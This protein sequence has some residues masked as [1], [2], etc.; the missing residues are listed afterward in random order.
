MSIIAKDRYTFRIKL[1]SSL[2]NITQFVLDNPDINQDGLREEGY[3]WTD[4][5]TIYYMSK[6]ADNFTM[7]RGGSS[8]VDPIPSQTVVQQAEVVQ[9]GVQTGHE[10]DGPSI[11]WPDVPIVGSVEDY[12][13][14]RKPSWYSRM[15]AMVQAGKH[16][17][18]AGPPGIGKSSAVE[19][20]AAE[21]GKV[22]VNVS[23]DSG[24]RRRDLTGQAANVNSHTAFFAAEYIA[25]AV[26]GWWVKVDEANAAEPDALMFLNSQIA[27]PHTVNFYGKSMPVHPGFRLFITYNP[28]LVGTKPLPDS[29]KDRFFPIKLEFPTANAL[30]RML[31]ANGMPNTDW[32]KAIVG[33]GVKAWEYHKLGRMRYQITPRRLMDAVTLVTLAGDDV[34]DALDAAVISAVDNVAEVRVLSDLLKSIKDEYAW[35]RL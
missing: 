20:L 35:G 11:H 24:L 12:P 33:F 27:P 18:L 2:A 8:Y 4:I 30:R 21:Q 31:E 3:S 25:A 32:S 15:A 26:N 9:Q 34:I 1:E 22:L 14:F 6:M 29:L 19:Y 28:G 10:F 5:N 7:G 16:I 17:S 13:W 23:S